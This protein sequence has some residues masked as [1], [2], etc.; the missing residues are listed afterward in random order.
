MK[1]LAIAVSA[2]ALFAAALVA[3]AAQAGETP[4]VPA[5]PGNFGLNDGATSYLPSGVTARVGGLSVSGFAPAQLADAKQAVD[6]ALARARLSEA[7]RERLEALSA[8]LDEAIA[9]QAL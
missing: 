2:S 9:A 1:T 7:D 6:R 3:G 4:V 8:E 5:T